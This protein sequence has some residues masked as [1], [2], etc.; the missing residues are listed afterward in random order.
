MT[1]DGL[2]GDHEDVGHRLAAEVVSDK[3][4]HR[5]R[6]AMDLDEKELNM[7]R[8]RLGRSPAFNVPKRMWN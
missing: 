7:P 4:A 1:P 8:Y 3:A 6:I 2:H 5:H